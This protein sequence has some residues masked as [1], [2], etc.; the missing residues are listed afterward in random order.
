[1]HYKGQD[2]LDDRSDVGDQADPAANQGELAA[3]FLNVTN[4]VTGWV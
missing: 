4:L 3:G 1:L 2:E